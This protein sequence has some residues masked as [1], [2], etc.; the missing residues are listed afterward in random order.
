L[1]RRVAITG[2]GR[3][4]SP[5]EL[6]RIF[7]NNFFENSSVKWH[8]RKKL[9]KKSTQNLS[10]TLKKAHFSE[11]GLWGGLGSSEKKNPLEAKLL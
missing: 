10:G 9:K 3:A 2:W 5:I 8:F 4:Q 6:S 11:T 1:N 7:L